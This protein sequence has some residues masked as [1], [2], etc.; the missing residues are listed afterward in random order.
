MVVA[1]KIEA[2]R[3]TG[4]L[5]ASSVGDVRARL[6]DI[7]DNHPIGD[8]V[9]DLSDVD[10]V[11]ATGL[12][13]LAATHRRLEREGRML[14]LRGCTAPIHRVLAVTRLLRV[15]HVEPVSRPA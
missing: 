10:L 9:V 6:N 12:G 5:D 11:D 15:L 2:L 4:R 14:V 3:L 7:I 1:G 13:V 8:I